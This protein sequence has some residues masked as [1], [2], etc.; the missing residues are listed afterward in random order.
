LPKGFGEQCGHQELL[1]APAHGGGGGG[2][3][4]Q[5]N[6]LATITHWRAACRQLHPDLP[7]SGYNNPALQWTQTSFIQP[8]MHPYDRFF[9]DDVNREYSVTRYLGDLTAR[10]GGVDAVLV[11]PTYPLLGIDDRSSHDMI[12]A[13][14]G[15]VPA[16]RWSFLN[17]FLAQAAFGVRAF[18]PLEALPCV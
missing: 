13:L 10:Y 15:G 2:G 11:W 14:P 7:T 16:V 1:M 9:Y 17:T 18:A 12:A 8:Q 5:A 4:G 3:G 6:W